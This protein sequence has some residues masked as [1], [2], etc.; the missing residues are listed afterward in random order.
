VLGIKWDAHDAN[1]AVTLDGRVLYVL[2]TERLF[3]VRYF[4]PKLSGATDATKAATKLWHDA[5][6][7]TAQQTGHSQFGDIV[8]VLA[9]KEHVEYKQRGA[10]DNVLTNVLAD[11]E[12]LPIKYANLRFVSHQRAHVLGAYHASGRFKIAFLL[13]FQ[14]LTKFPLLSIIPFL[15]NTHSVI[16]PFF[17]L[18]GMRNALVVVNHGGGGWTDMEMQAYAVCDADGDKATRGRTRAPKTLLLGDSLLDPCLTC[19]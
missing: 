12:A 11:R 10:V 19:T 3:R 2:E 18:P 6:A 17:P 4:A 16:P 9:Y 15:S 14:I 7:M 8:V 1:V 5:L 13:I